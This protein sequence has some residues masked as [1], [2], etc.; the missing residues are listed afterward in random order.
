MKKID[1]SSLLASYIVK[2]DLQQYMDS[3][4]FEI[5]TLQSFEKDEHLI[6]TGTISD[7]LYFL[8][9][10]TVMVYSY[11]TDTQNICID[12]ASEMTPLG[13]ASSLWEILPK[14]SVKAA[15]PCI[16]ICISLSKYRTL[17][18]KD[19][20]FLQNVCQLLSNR[21]N[22]GITLANSLAES[23]TVRLAKFI[24]ANQKETIF[25][26][27]LTTCAEI[28]NVSYRHL[29]RMMTRFKEQ[30]I[31]EKYENYYIIRDFQRLENL[32]LER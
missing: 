15:T 10:G 29:L 23:V 32:A 17:L 9:D 11:A 7:F 14:S 28:L 26:F 21:L 24:L 25:S 20:R 3:D 2:H 6:H 8:V 30:E 27:Q 16:C 12:Y 18:Q 22:T 4:L 5:A 1:D 31:L 13:E 19:I